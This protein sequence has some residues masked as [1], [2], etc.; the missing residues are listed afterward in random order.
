MRE[1]D[2]CGLCEGSDARAWR[3]GTAV[4]FPVR[5][6]RGGAE[7]VSGAVGGNRQMQSSDV[8]GYLRVVSKFR[9]TVLQAVQLGTEWM[10]RNVICPAKSKN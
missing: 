5:L 3:G 4:P 9:Y 10:A 6:G 8:V 7:E 1:R 2:A